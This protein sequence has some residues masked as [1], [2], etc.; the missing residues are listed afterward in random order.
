G[1]AEAATETRKKPAGR[2]RVRLLCILQQVAGEEQGE[3]SGGHHQGPDRA[4]LAVGH[5]VELLGGAPPGVW[6]GEQQQALEHGHQAKRRPQVAQRSSCR[7]FRNGSS[8]SSTIAAL[9][10]AKAL[11]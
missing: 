5:G 1:A 11:R 4:Q 3:Q 9:P 8:R 7:Y 6:Q 2:T 10:L